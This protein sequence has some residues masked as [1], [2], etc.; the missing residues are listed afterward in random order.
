MVEAGIEV[1]VRTGIPLA[2]F[3]WLYSHYCR[4]GAQ[5]GSGGVGG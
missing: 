5:R 3:L 2:L 1:L 4:P